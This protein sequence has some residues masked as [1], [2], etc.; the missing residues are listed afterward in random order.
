MTATNL[1]L[2]SRLRRIGAAILVVGGLSSALAFLAAPDEPAEPAA[3]ALE[4]GQAVPIWQYD[5]KRD[6]HQ[7]EMYGGKGAVTAND[8]RNWLAGLWQGKRR[9]YTLA[10]LTL[11]LA[12][13]CFW[14]A[15]GLNI[16]PAQP[17]GRDAP[18]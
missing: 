4:N 10:W 3:Y 16:A 12:L 9:A 11:G 13:A 18:R 8:L 15:Q 17:R 2:Q 5:T 6:E 7:I 1:A 14:A